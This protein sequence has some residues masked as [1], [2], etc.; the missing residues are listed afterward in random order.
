MFLNMADLAGKVALVTGVAN[1]RSIAYAVAEAFAAAG[2]RQII[3][4]LP[5]GKEAERE[6]IERLTEHLQ[7]AMLLPLDV[8]DPASI[9]TLYERIGQEF[10]TL[11]IL[12]HSIASAKREELAGRFSD[13]SEEGF[14]FAQTISAYSLISLARGA[15]PLM[16]EHGA[17]ILTLSYIGSVRAAPNYNVMGAAKAALEANVRYLAMELG[18]EKIRV[19]AISAGPIRTL[20]ASGVK[21]FLDLM[22]TAQAN[23]ALKRNITQEEVA[24]T[25]AFLGSDGA[26]GI[27]GQVLYVDGGY[28][29]SG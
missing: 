21:D 15:R 14:Q 24:H 28:N 9:S 29:I 5:M 8:A 6:K 12:V 10:G 2:A 17:S 19:N 22:H 23:N 26:S 3:T 25:A 1:K 7:P 16:T 13:I 18:P 27:T 4:Y 20:S 11:D